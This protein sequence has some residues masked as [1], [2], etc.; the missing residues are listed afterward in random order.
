MRR[1]F[2]VLGMILAVT[3]AL[4]VYLDGFTW[5][6]FVLCYLGSSTALLTCWHAFISAANTT[7]HV[8]K[9]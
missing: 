6:R 4:S 5:W 2:F 7:P 1:T 8:E 9:P 3:S